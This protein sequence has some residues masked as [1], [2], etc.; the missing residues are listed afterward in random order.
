VFIKIENKMKKLENK[1]AVVYSDGTIG[2]TIAKAFAREGAKVFLTGRTPAKLKKIAD[3]ILADGGEVETAEV[4]A[5]NESA[6]DT[7]M[8][9]LIN[10]SGK[11]DIS[12]NAIGLSQTGIPRAALIE[13]SVENFSLP[14]TTYTLSH[15]ITA[16]AAARQMVK[17]KNGVIIMHI[18]DPAR[19]SAPFLG[20]RAPAYAAVELL[21][22]SLSM[23]YA[24][25]GVRSVCLLTTGLPETPLIQVAFN[26]YAK[27]QDMSYEQLLSS[28]EGKT[29][30]KQLTTL[31]ELTNT[32]VFVAS[33]EGTAF[34]GTTLNLT[35]GMIAN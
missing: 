35:A 7:H 20:G 9:E 34:T 11:V 15:F 24:Q 26:A 17:Q 22:R 18:P 14:I 23:E 3:E 16:R 33:D 1:V 2:A 10:R 8:S 28:I 5:L 19:T 29:H 31:T 27:A 32:A 4:D 25:Y 12:F 30:R 6:V 21:C 13:L